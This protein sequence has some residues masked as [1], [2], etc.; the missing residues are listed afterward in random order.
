LPYESG[1]VVRHGATAIVA[2]GKGIEAVST[3]LAGTGTVN[4]GKW[5]NGLIAFC[6][7][8]VREL[9]GENVGC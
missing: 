9:E 3:V 6:L 7:A 1:V 8:A 2:V 5:G 4:L